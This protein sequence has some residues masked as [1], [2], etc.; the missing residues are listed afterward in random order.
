MT[1]LAGKWVWIW[2]W[3]R[4]DGGDVAAVAARLRR[5][6]CVGALVKAHDGPHWRSGAFDQGRPW[7]E[8]C[9]ALKAEGIR[10]AGWGYLY[11]AD[12]EGE[13][14]RAIETAQYGEAEAYVLD[15]EAEFEGRPEAAEAVCRPIRQALGPEYPLYYSTFAI[16]RYHRSFPY[17]VFNRYCTGALPQAYY[18][19][20]G[21]P[22]ERALTWMYEDYTAL[23]LGGE[24][25]F[26][27][28]GAYQEGAVPSPSP[29]SL[30]QFAALARQQG[31]LGLSFWSY[32]H[33]DE[34]MWQAVAAIDLAG[35][36]NGAGEVLA[37]RPLHLTS[38]AFWDVPAE[39]ALQPARLDLRAHFGLPTEAK[40]VDLLV[41]VRSRWPGAYLALYDPPGGWPHL[42]A[43]VNAQHRDEV[44]F[45]R[46][47]VRLTE[48]G[49]LYWVVR[50]IEDAPLH[51][52][53]LVVGVYS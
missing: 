42:V 53:L 50:P 15:V 21:W 20:F 49:A 45:Q 37:Y 23:G 43:Y 11:G 6:G 3:R 36:D 40:Y 44:N 17:D 51:V 4:A 10:C 39:A 18:N 41:G 25:L 31:S 29:E 1:L 22:V 16:A 30:Q 35:S 38:A 48:E 5:A 52:Y 9:R 27:V 8:I 47:R 26:P 28:A 34:A 46:A 32:E 24:R 7:R 14:Q 2:N 19:A 12:P 13:A 33:M